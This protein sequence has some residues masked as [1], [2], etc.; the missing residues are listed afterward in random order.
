VQLTLILLAAQVVNVL[1]PHPRLPI[2][3]IS[4]I[5][6]TVK[7][8][9]PTTDTTASEKQNKVGQKAEIMARNARGEGR[10]QIGL[11]VRIFLSPSR[12]SRMV[13]GTVTM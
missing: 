5:D 7:L 4:G 9:G 12:A 13:L 2:L 3:A 10:A 8:F 11:S 1:Q 6:E